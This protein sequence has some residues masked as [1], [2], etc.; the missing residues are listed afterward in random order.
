MASYRR[1]LEIKPD[2]AEVHSN[3]GNA[4]H[5]FGRLADAVACYRRA[6]EIKPGLADA[7]SNLIFCLDLMPSVGL[8]EQ[9]EERRRW[10]EA[11]AAPLWQEPVHANDRSPA[12]RLRVG[13]V[14]G[15]LREHSACKTF[16]GILTQYDRSQ[17]EVFAYSNYRG[18]GDA[19]T[20]RF[21][22]GVTVWRDIGHLSDEAV[23]K[24]IRE[25][26]I[27]ILVDL[28]GHSAGNRLL[29]FARKPAPIQ[30]TGWGYGS[31]T[32][33][34][35]MDVFFP[36]AVLGPPEDKRYFT[37]EVRYQ[38][39]AWACYAI[40]PFPEANALPALADGIL[41]FGSFNRL[42]KVVEKAYGG[43]AE[44]LL[45]LPGSRLLL[46]TAELE[47]AG[48]RERF[49][50]HCTRAGVAAERVIMLGKTPWNAHVQAY[51]RV[52]LALDPFPCGGGITTLEGL[53]MG[54]PAITLRW[55]TIAGGASASVV[56]ALGLT[57][58]IGETQEQYVE[59]A[60]RKASDLRSLAALRGQ[61][62]GIVTSALSDQQAYVR[63]GEAEYR[64]R[65]QHRG[66]S[67]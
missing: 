59:L 24:L 5:D 58:W 55:P 26:R 52:D 9:H 2:L 36:D 28:S 57:D 56:T 51:H 30:I 14:S 6:L 65:G 3:L 4:L 42:A 29:V 48:I 60:V 62:R 27:D 44:V 53:M 41:T 1:A 7:R 47:D 31:S 49:A 61:L 19:F 43:W 39:S 45:A 11:H 67:G 37:E 54:V 63:S 25:D 16:I 15:D 21:R 34:R 12:R 18:K 66:P 35:A 22:Q 64:Q 10:D 38:S 8:V 13:Y 40:E 50:G 17:F 23:A 32:G 46:K 33:M 20:E